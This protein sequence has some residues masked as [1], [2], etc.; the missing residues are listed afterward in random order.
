MLR[1]ADSDSRANVR[2]HDRPI[3]EQ[4]RYLPH[5]IL[6]VLAPRPVET[7]SLALAIVAHQHII[8]I[9]ANARVASR[10]Y[11][12]F[13]FNTYDRVAVLITTDHAC[14]AAH[15]C[16]KCCMGTSA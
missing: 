16:C 1:H 4:V 11:A 3:T 10:S 9:V 12:I 5:F 15:G 8:C 14:N 7:A 13:G 2:D 6:L